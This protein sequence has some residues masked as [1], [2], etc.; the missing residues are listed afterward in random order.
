MSQARLNW[1]RTARNALMACL[2]VAACAACANVHELNAA[3]ESVQANDAQE[4]CRRLGLHPDTHVYDRCVYREYREG[5]RRG[6][7][8]RHHHH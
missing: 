6:Q 4:T 3:L 7:R 8:Y 1:L 5:E 2:M